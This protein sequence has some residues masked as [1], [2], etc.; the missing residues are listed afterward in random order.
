MFKLNANQLTNEVLQ[1]YRT[2]RAYGCYTRNCLELEIWPDVAG[3]VRYVVF[4]DIDQMHAANDAYGYAVVDGKIRRAIN[5][6]EADIV[7]ARW[8]SGD[9][10]V[11]L[12]LD[13]QRMG[14]PIKFAGRI[15]A[16]FLKEGLSA[17]F[18]ITQVQAGDLAPQMVV[19]R[20]A[21]LVQL[22]KRAGETASIHSDVAG[23]PDLSVVSQPV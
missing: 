15:Q 7:V 21:R 20:A 16:R 2:D 14:D 11:F 3:R 9:E 19:G 18:G 13:G 10:L 6:R 17:T 8:Y 5:G 4:C 12:I 1:Q 22:A 23:L